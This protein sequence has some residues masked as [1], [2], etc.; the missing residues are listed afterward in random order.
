MA[1]ALIPLPDGIENDIT[2]DQVEGAD[3]KVRASSQ[4]AIT[5]NLKGW[6]SCEIDQTETSRAGRPERGLCS[7]SSWPSSTRKVTMGTHF[8]TDY[9]KKVFRNEDA[10]EKHLAACGG[11][12]PI[13]QKLLGAMI[14]YKRTGSRS[15]VSHWLSVASA[16]NKTE[17]TGLLVFF[18]ELSPHA[19][20]EQHRIA[21]QCL[22]FFVR[23][24]L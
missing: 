17:A 10:P 21:E 23:P 20:F 3:K 6:S 18:N 9:L 1:S 14:L 4:K 5:D 12:E 24:M 16:V 7:G 2:K 8:M 11:N 15:G 19:S 22:N 13:Q